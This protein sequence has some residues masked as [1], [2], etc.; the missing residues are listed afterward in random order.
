M[1][2]ESKRK[3]RQIL[4]RF[5]ARKKMQLAIAQVG[6]QA[7]LGSSQILHTMSQPIHRHLQHSSG[8]HHPDPASGQP[9]GIISR[10]WCPDPEPVQDLAT[11]ILLS[12]TWQALDLRLQILAADCSDPEK[13]ARIERKRAVMAS[14]HSGIQGLSKTMDQLSQASQF[15][16]EVQKRI[17]MKNRKGHHRTCRTKTK[18]NF[19]P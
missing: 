2:L 9:P 6:M 5:Q 7:A 8:G 10:H 11:G 13:A 19:Q 14:L 15:F 16:H 3:K 12:R 17:R 1:N 4:A 18:N